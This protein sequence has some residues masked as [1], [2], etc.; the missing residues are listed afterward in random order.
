MDNFA[1]FKDILD[2]ELKVPFDIISYHDSMNRYGCDK[3]DRRFGMEL[4]DLTDDLKNTNQY[5]VGSVNRES[6]IER[7]RI[8]TSWFT[9]EYE[10]IEV[11]FDKYL[12]FKNL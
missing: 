5:P 3:P 9:N 1:L 4:V 12:N 2:I 7:D 6:K 8:L 11:K 10:N